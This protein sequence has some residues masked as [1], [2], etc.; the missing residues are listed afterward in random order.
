MKCQRCFERFDKVKPLTNRAHTY[1]V[2]H[3]KTTITTTVTHAYIQTVGARL[4]THSHLHL[5]TS[6]NFNSRPLVAA[7]SL[8]RSLQLVC[9]NERQGRKRSELLICWVRF[10]VL[11]KFRNFRAYAVVISRWQKWKQKTTLAKKAKIAEARRLR[12]RVRTCKRVSTYVW[13]L[14]HS[15]AQEI[16]FSCN[17]IDEHL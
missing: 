8:S 3:T 11:R 6:A 1:T 17:D 4:P 5:I 2:T 16:A 15:K 14:W 12:C 10:K 7:R 9:A 13:R